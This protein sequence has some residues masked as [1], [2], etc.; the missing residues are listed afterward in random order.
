MHS[1]LASQIS[2][3]RSDEGVLDV[4]ALCALVEKT[5]TQMDQQRA[6]GERAIALMVKE[7]EEANAAR[8]ATLE[9][10]QQEHARLDDALENMAQGIAMY[11]SAGRLIVANSRFRNFAQIEEG[12]SIH[13]PDVLNHCIKR[14]ASYESPLDDIPERM[15]R[16]E[17]VERVL[18]LT[19][20]Q[21]F[22]IACQPRRNGGW[23]AVHR[24]ITE[25][26]RAS[27]QIRFLARHDSLTGLSNRVVINDAIDKEV[28]NIRTG[29]NVAVLCLD[30]DRFKAVN[31]T[32]GHPTGDKLLQQVA[33]RLREAAAE[34]VA[35][36]RLGGDE[37]VLVQTASG[38][39][40][41]AQNLARHIVDTIGKPYMIEGHAIVVGVSIGIA[42]ASPQS[43]DAEALMRN[44]DIALYRAKSGGRSAYR[45]FEPQM[46]EEIQ[47]RRRLE[48]D[49][50]R[51]LAD[52]EFEL[53][54][55]PL[56][57][58]KSRSVQTC[59]AMLRW[60]RGG[61]EIVAPDIFVPLA[62]EIGLIRDIGAWALMEACMCAARWPDG[63]RVAVNVS[64]AQ[65]AAPGLVDTVQRALALSGLAA[66][67]LEIEIV[68]TILLGDSDQAVRILAQLRK[69]GVRV[70][71]DAFGAGYSSL[72]YLR[73]FPFDKLKI[74]RSF[75]VDLTMNP[76][77]DA[78]VRA[79]IQ[80]AA[81][82][83]MATSADGVESAAQADLLR[84]L[85]C[86]EAQGPLFH[87][88]APAREID[89]LLRAPT[90]AV[91]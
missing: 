32:L 30:L 59:E 52:G 87:G 64:R 22:A 40:A 27:E 1:V 50:R 14:I 37:F 66:D 6:R 16:G 3:S 15:A 49:L 46:G 75:I 65:F 45:F 69:L 19:N 39:P 68:E 7:I 89:A 74:D 24:D 86:T 31:D 56:V 38:Q 44:A 29:E 88:A 36:G 57:T 51:A 71:M 43:P 85:N 8:E 20:G 53:H 5:Y 58:L 13:F 61:R 23:V 84:A 48:I 4:E 83:G 81:A 80:I 41:A 42:L 70:A 63:I 67:R 72:N 12:A 9:R 18:T 17:T 47:E 21:I 78:I 91:A 2:R 73:R 62:E 26:Q 25:Q 76:E 54:F 55:Q 60:R 33:Q 90:I 10:L 35:I 82:L 77:A 79:I 11:D 34:A 28:A